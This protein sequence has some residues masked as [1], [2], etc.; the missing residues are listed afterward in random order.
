M[1]ESLRFAAA[2][3]GLGEAPRGW[4]Q[5]RGDAGVGRAQSLRILLGVQYRQIG[6]PGSVDEQRSVKDD[7][8]DS[9]V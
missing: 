7:A 8:I 9:T 5:G 3:C 2:K 6:Q 4:R 1:T